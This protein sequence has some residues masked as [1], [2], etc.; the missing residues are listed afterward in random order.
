V[1]KKRPR[2]YPWPLHALQICSTACS[3]AGIGSWSRALRRRSQN[4][5]TLRSAVAI[6]QCRGGG[7]RAGSLRS[8]H[9]LHTRAGASQRGAAR[10]REHDG[11][12]EGQQSTRH[13]ITSFLQPGTCRPATIA[14]PG[15]PDKRA[16]GARA[17]N[18]PAGGKP[19]HFLPPHG[20]PVTRECPPRDGAPPT[21]WRIVLHLRPQDIQAVSSQCLY[22][23]DRRI[24]GASGFT[25]LP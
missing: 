23:P 7:R 5:G 3:R 15:A 4:G 25:S 16:P 12:N 9:R 20:P 1:N 24:R 13:R 6:V 2:C 17:R 22:R 14:D 19:S 21:F 18:R 8:G 11:G 10:H